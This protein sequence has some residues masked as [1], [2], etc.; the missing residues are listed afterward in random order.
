MINFN[1]L[2]LASETQLVDEPNSTTADTFLEAAGNPKAS[3]NEILGCPSGNDK[4][5]SAET[6]GD[7]SKDAAPVS[8]ALDVAGGSAIKS[9]W[10]PSWAKI[11]PEERQ[12]LHDHVIC[13][14][15]AKLNAA[16]RSPRSRGGGG[17][18]RLGR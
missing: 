16:R 5:T 9:S 8:V 18:R 4:E 11:T 17:E 15:F 10:L 7:Q 12:K 13:R 6:P 1:I 2:G 14:E 3:V